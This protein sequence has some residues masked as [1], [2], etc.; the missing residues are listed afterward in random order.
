M[1]QPACSEWIFLGGSNPSESNRTGLDHGQRVYPCCDERKQ[2]K[3]TAGVTSR[4]HT[5]QEVR[6]TKTEYCGQHRGDNEA[7]AV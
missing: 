4:M 5:Q 3:D 2:N 7:I 6:W 1:Q